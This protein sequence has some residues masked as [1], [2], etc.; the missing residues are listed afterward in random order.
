M[1]D[2]NDLEEV[3]GLSSD[4]MAKNATFD[5]VADGICIN[6]GCDYSTQV[7][8]DCDNGWCEHCQTNTVQSILV[9][10]GMI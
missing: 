4:E 9:L 8:P 1:G 10:M 3:T 5:S 6:D 7:E 2:I